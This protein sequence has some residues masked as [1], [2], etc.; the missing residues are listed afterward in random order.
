LLLCAATGLAGCAAAVRP[1]GRDFPQNAM[2][3]FALDR[4]SVEEAQAA[5]GPPLKSTTVRGLVAATSKRLVPGSAYSV[6]LLNYL[7]LPYGP[8]QPRQAHPGKA[9]ILV[10]L[11]GRLIA[12]GSDDSIPGQ[13]NPPINDAALASLHQCQTTKADVIALLGPPNGQTL[14]LLDAQ[15]GAVDMIYSW[16]ATDAGVWQQH[17]LHVF[18]DKTGAMSNYTLVQTAAPASGV[19]VTAPMPQPGHPPVALPP[20][21]PSRADREHT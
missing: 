3:G 11:N 18:F 14:H 8:G 13:E 16:S 15:P 7:F 5:L 21:C 20:A 10:F 4:T 19:Q 12:Y 17:S 2:S 1:V 6:T 9:A